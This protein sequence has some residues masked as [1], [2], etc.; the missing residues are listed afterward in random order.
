M[1]REEDAAAVGAQVATDTLNLYREQRFRMA[2]NAALF[3]AGGGVAGMSESFA[4]A[5]NLSAKLLGEQ[6]AD[7]RLSGAS[8][9]GRLQGAAAFGRGNAQSLRSA[10]SGVRRAALFGALTSIA[11]TAAQSGVFDSAAP[12]GAS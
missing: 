9:E 6:V 12:A 3:A 11:G 4:A 2:S 7:T 1:Q 10:K 5:A 8:R